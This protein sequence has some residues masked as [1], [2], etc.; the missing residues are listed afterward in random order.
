[1]AL[2]LL[3][4]GDG[5]RALLRLGSEVGPDARRVGQ[6]RSSEERRKTYADECDIIMPVI[7]RSDE[8][9][10]SFYPPKFKDVTRGDPCR[11]SHI[12]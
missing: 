1:M 3:Q 8:N 10:P 6:E 11:A 9:K 5:A 4:N 7:Q 12:K 2:A